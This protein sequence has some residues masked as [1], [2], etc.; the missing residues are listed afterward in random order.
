[1][2][3]VQ[4]SIRDKVK[5]GKFPAPKGNEAFTAYAIAAG[6]GLIPEMESAAR[7]T[8]DL[9]MTFQALGKKLRLFEGWAL[10]NLVSFRKRCKDCLITC[11][12]SFLEAKPPGPSN[13]WTN[14]PEATSRAPRDFRREPVPVLPPWLNDLLSRNQKDLKLQTFSRSLDIHSRIRR[15][16]FAALQSHGNCYTCSG[17]HTRNGSTF[18]AEL[19]NKLAQAYNKVLNS[20]YLTSTTN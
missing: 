9:P 18:F 1:M 20:L 6:R 13:I 12:G 16:Y 3:S 19:E 17:V 7:Q 2:V 11:L 15:E 14:C 10:R 5:C 4:S 8:L